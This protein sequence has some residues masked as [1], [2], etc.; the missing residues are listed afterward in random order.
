MVND[1]VGALHVALA[2]A[3]MGW[4][5]FS[6]SHSVAVWKK[7]N[8]ASAR[9]SPGILYVGLLIFI[10]ALAAGWLNRE[11]TRRAGAILGTDFFV[12]H[13][14]E[15]AIPHLADGDSI[16]RGSALVTFENPAD[17]REEE[18]LRSEITAIEAQM[19]GTQLSPLAIDP[20]LLRRSQDAQESERAR[21]TQLGFGVLPTSQSAPAQDDQ[22]VAAERAR[23]E[24][25]TMQLERTK[26]LVKDGIVAESN[27]E[28]ATAAAQTAAQQLHEREQLIRATK[29]GAQDV[30]ATDAAIR[31]DSLRASSR[32]T[33]E[34]TGLTAH[35]VD[36]RATLAELQLE[37]SVLA[38][39]GGTVVYRNPAPALASDH[40]AILALAKGPGF[41]ARIEVP[42]REAAMLV[43]GQELRMKL[44][45]SLVSDLVSGRLQSV[46]PATGAPDRRDLIIACNLPPEQFAAFASGAIPVQLEWR[47]PLYTDHL[48][49]AGFASLLFALIVWL[50]T[51]A[52]AKQ[53]RDPEASMLTEEVE[54]AFAAQPVLTPLLV[55][56]RRGAGASSPLADPDPEEIHRVLAG[57]ELETHDVWGEA[58]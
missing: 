39:F 53:Q 16:A 45:H 4:L 3:I 14:H 28:T 55:K 56:A 5:V 8:A 7:R 52:R 42:S 11:M 13:A 33:A 26:A 19:A 6:I 51:V 40:Q 1:S 54:H 32:R 15:N 20:D 23:S 35:L 36:L 37:R 38:P 58:R 43:P 46:L 49:Q 34:L 29:A 21:L 17:N 24:A 47:P 31:R 44:N 2:A 30:A 57:F 9:G 27:L 18:H 50:V 41:L 25:A 12:V 48:A 22:L 10:A